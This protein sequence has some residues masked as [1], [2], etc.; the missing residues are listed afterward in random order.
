MTLLH[1]ALTVRLEDLQL[2]A[3]VA[4]VAVNARGSLLV[5]GL[6]DVPVCA[7]EVALHGDCRGATVALAAAHVQTG[8]TL[9]AMNPSFPTGE[10]PEAYEDLI[11]ELEDVAAEIVDIMP[12]QN[13]VNKVFD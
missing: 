1:S 5:D 4:M 7:Q 6:C 2:A 12:A 11:K 10:C 13:V 3:N 9:A 8:H